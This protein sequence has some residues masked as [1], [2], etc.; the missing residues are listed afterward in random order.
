MSE[1]LLLENPTPLQS[2]RSF[3]RAPLMESKIFF[4]HQHFD[5]LPPLGPLFRLVT[6]FSQ[7]LS[8]RLTFSALNRKPSREAAGDPRHPD[9]IRPVMAPYP[10]TFYP[11]ANF[12]TLIGQFDNLAGIP[13]PVPERVSSMPMAVSYS[14]LGPHTEPAVACAPDTIHNPYFPSLRPVYPADYVPGTAVQAFPTMHAPAAVQGYPA[15][16]IQLEIPASVNRHPV[17][18]V[19]TTPEQIMYAQTQQAALNRAPYSDPG[20]YTVGQPVLTSADPIYAGIGPF[21]GFV[22]PPAVALSAVPNNVRG[23]KKTLSP[24]IDAL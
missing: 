22:P 13:G 3:G 21:N 16:P 5:T 20:L 19:Q 4:T 18:Y 15:A 7:F 10:L 9:D 24:P 17:N 1:P 12:P 11:Q 23:T 14:V 8:S 2:T 6:D